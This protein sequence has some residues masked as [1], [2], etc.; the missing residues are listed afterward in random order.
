MQTHQKI[1]QTY[2][3]RFDELSTEKRFHFASR[4]KLWSS[5]ASMAKALDAM[6][7]V[8]IGTGAADYT[9]KINQL[10]TAQINIRQLNAASLR[11][12]VLEKYPWLYGAELVLFYLLHANTHYKKDLRPYANN[13]QK[14]K[15]GIRQLATT[16][17]YALGVLSTYAINVLYLVAQF[18]KSQDSFDFAKNIDAALGLA[19][20]HPDEALLK[21][22]LITHCIIGETLFYSKPIAAT[23]APYYEQL[24]HQGLELAEKNW[25]SLSLD[26]KLELAVCCRILD[27]APSLLRRILNET[28]K[29]YESDL[30]YIIDPSKP[31]KNDLEWAEHRNVLFIM[32]STQP[33]KPFTT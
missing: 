7:D 6:E 25:S 1:T 9:S 22:Y 3:T 30:R 4:L 31:H 29:Y 32:A 20:E 5:D 24:L 15:T 17:P 18:D 8:V 21:L 33:A 16:D 13:L 2:K 12:P 27:K 26:A 23:K 11:T 19:I 14:Y 10:E 28:E